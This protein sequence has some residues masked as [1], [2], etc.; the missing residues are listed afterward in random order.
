[1]RVLGRALVIKTAVWGKTFILLPIIYIARYLVW[2]FRKKIRRNMSV[3][4]KVT[5]L[6]HGVSV[7]DFGI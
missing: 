3:G 6:G 2:S 7:T 4:L 5:K 1:M